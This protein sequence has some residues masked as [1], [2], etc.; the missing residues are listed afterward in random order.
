MKMSL[1]QAKESFT[2]LRTSVEVLIEKTPRRKLDEVF[3]EKFIEIYTNATLGDI[4]AQDYLGYIF[5]RGRQ[6]LVPENID[7]SMKWLI[8]AAANG[9]P[10]S[11]HRLAIFLNFAYDEV[12]YHEDFNLIAYRNGLS[13]ENHTYVIGKLVCEAIIDAMNINPLEIIKEVPQT[14]VFNA[15][16]MGLYDKARNNAIPVVLTYLRG[17]NPHAKKA[18][19]VVKAPEKKRKKLFARRPNFSKPGEENPAENPIDE[20]K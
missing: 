19:E 2:K 9:N 1:S 17:I 18:E 7:L 15:A 4:V 6:G 8:L 11:I 14:L 16:T 12:V 3:A 5:K 10:M 13:E 20:N